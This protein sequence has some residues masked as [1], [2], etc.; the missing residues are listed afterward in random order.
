VKN[1]PIR[2]LKGFTRLHLAKGAT[3]TVSFRLDD[4]AL[5]T[6]DLTGTRTVQPGT[7]QVWLGGGQP[8]ARAG[9]TQPPGV[10]TSFKIEG[11]PRLLPE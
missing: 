10:A 4:R 1:Q 5:S 9:L 8:G 11:L 2:A 6:V 7:A 3:R